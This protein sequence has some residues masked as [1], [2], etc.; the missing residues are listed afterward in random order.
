MSSEIKFEKV[1]R[2]PDGTI[3]NSMAEAQAYLRTPKIREELMSFTNNNVELTE[4][5]I[6]NQELVEMSFETGT[7]R[8]VTKA[9]YAKLEKA[10]QAVVAANDSSMKF[11]ADNSAAI[12]ESFRWPSVRR[13]TEDEKKNAARNTLIAHSQDEGLADWILANRS[14]ILA[15][16]N[17]G[18]QKRQV[19]PK[20]TEGL[21]AYREKVRAEK[22]QKDMAAAAAA[23]MTLEDYLGS[24]K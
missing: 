12:L 8:R 6:T 9:E 3:F 1:I 11:I 10:L 22:L 16:Y 15:A 21:A 20:A 17:A 4:W 7:I 5:L 2:L 23:G 18:V 13:M 24:K 19:S 14:E